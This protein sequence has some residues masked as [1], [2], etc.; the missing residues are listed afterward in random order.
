MSGA[1]FLRIK[2]LKRNG[3]ITVAARHN[4]REI[5]AEMGATGSIDPTHSHLN[6]VIAGPAAAA[7]G[8]G[9]LAKD[10]M[11]AA[12]V[13][14]TRKDAV[15]GLEI[16]FSLPHGH[17]IDDRGYFE[18]CTEWA[19]RYFGG[20]VLSSDVHKD[21]ANDHC[22]VLLLP[23]IDGRMDGGRVVGNKQKLI[24]MQKH[25]HNGVAQRYGLS[26]AAAK[27]T[28]AAKQLA[29]KAVLDRLRETGDKAMQSQLWATIR[30]VIESDPAPFLMALGIK[31][32][33]VAKKLRTVTQIMTSKG[34][35]KNKEPISIDFASTKKE[36]SLCSVD[37]ASKPAP[38]QPPK[39]PQHQHDAPFV[40]LTTRHRDSDQT[41]DRYSD[42]SGDYYPTQ[43]PAP[44]RHRQAVNAA[45]MALSSLSTGA[46][47]RSA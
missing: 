8:V 19:S 2:K 5:Q 40:E 38:P 1:A 20:H 24:E 46:R 11:T 12:G 44:R 34:K 25:F 41:T 33:A 16:V 36:R 4:K 43:A 21:E 42:D 3:I 39:Q 27:L 32:L 10:L 37:F 15:M 23:L 35:G 28:G 18:D 29:S 13:T 22:H 26:K 31:P 30:D 47:L 14:K 7:A 45:L 17:T 9:Q 6:Y